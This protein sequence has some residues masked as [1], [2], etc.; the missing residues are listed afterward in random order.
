VAYFSYL[1]IDIF[2]D[3]QGYGY[4]LILLHG[5]SVSSKMF[6]KD[7]KFLS[8]FFQTIIIDF[9]GHGKSDRL[10]QFHDDFWIFNANAVVAL[11]EH[12]E[13][14]K[15]NII[16]T[17]GGAL[18]GLNICLIAPNL[19]NKLVAD[20]FLGMKMTHELA[21]HL[22]KDRA[23]AVNQLLAKLFWRQQHGDDWRSVVDKDTQMILKCADNGG[24]VLV[25]DPSKIF[26]PVLATASLEDNLIPDIEPKIR[27]VMNR[28]PNSIVKIYPHGKHTFMVSNRMEFRKIVLEFFES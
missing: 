4:P 28:I 16:G 9:P 19:V 11:T 27:E 10:T 1:D 17:S 23:K 7:V 20:S 22:A 21:D 3:I 18:V 25:D 26:C 2:Y 8:K 15:I 13:I 5:N 6:E 14:E 24:R 12:L